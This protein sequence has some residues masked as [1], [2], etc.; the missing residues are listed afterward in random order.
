MSKIYKQK[1]AKLITLLILNYHR[2]KKI[3]FSNFSV[4]AKGADRI[5]KQILSN[6]KK[7]VKI[8]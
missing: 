3:T 8:L 7:I 4:D 2:L 5:I 1:I 6:S